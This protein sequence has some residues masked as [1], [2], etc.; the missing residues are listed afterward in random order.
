YEFEGQR[1]DCGDKFGYLQA[2][3]EFALMH[4]EFGKE[5][6]AYLDKRMVQTGKKSRSVAKVTCAG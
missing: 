4:P 1:F 5:F 3:V 2:I 6:K